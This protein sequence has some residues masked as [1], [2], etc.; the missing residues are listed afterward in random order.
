MNL[1][2]SLR[3][4]ILKSKKT[5]S[6]Y[7]ALVAGGLGPVTSMLDLIFDGVPAEDRNLLLHKMFTT[8][9][10]MTGFLLLPLFVVLVC[11]LLPQIEYKNNAWKQVLTSPQTKSNV[12]VAKFLNVHLLI[13]LFLLT[14]QLSMFAVAVVLHFMQP[15]LNLLH[16]PVNGYAVFLTVAN[17]YATLLALCTIQFWLG[18]R[19][20]NFVVPV[21][22]GLSLWFIGSLMV[23]Q[24]E[25]R[26][27]LYFP[28]SFH[29]YS[30]FPKYGSHLPAVQWTSLGYAV[31]FLIAGFVDFQ[32][33][34]MTG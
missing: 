28:Y 7:L 5:A 17:S 14:N 24:F 25:T 26:V 31:L 4:E 16:Q 29:V 23:M 12:W 9:F 11:T 2:L 15:S 27:A 10:Q 30:S 3:S 34:R 21:A 20:K 22:I 18:I 33:R 1:L 8:R 13:L 19:F 6:F 32:K